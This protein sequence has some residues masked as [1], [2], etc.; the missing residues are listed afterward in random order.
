[1][2]FA[3]L[4]TL[5]GSDQSFLGFYIQARDAKGTPIGQFIP[6]DGLVKTHGCGG[7]KN[8]IR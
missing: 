8:V 7:V 5:G 4:V 3:F 1:M 2:Q 6:D